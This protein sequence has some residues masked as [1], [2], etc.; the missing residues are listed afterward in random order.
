MFK[1]TVLTLAAFVAASAL[2]LSQSDTDVY[3]VTSPIRPLEVSVFGTDINANPLPE[4]Y[5]SGLLEPNQAKSL[6]TTLNADTSITTIIH[7][8][9]WKDEGHTTIDFQKWY[10]YDPTPTKISFYLQSAQQVFE[11]TAIPGRTAFQ[12]VYIHLNATLS[13]GK[14]EWADTVASPVKLV[15]PISYSITVTKEQTQFLQDLK[16][17]LQVIGLTGLVPAAAAPPQPGYFSITTFESQWSTSSIQVA[18]T[19][20][21]S[22]TQVTGTDPSKKT[23]SNQLTSNTYQNEKPSWIG[24]SAGVPITTYKEVTYQQ[25]SGTFVPTSITRQNAYVFLDGY[26]PPVLPSLASFRLLPQPFYGLPLA[27]KV[28]RH[29]MVGAGIGLRWLEPF[30]GVIFDTQS[31]TLVG[32]TP[33]SH[34]QYQWVFGIKISISA[35]ASAVK[36]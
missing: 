16:T 21:P 33:K 20:T 35:L 36:K 30:G 14:D 3:R 19:V 7:I 5:K 18:L 17:L 31:E 8:L 25:S 28:L 27:G 10:L 12:F 26:L 6:L 13:K 24:L 29:Q 9:R 22:T 4:P 34:I 32:G 2:C 11:R 15:H 1:I 23:P